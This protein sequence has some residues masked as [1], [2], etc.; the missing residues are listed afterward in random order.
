MGWTV[1]RLVVGL[2][3]LLT[4]F[5]PM[6]IPLPLFS[7]PPA[8]A[9]DILF[10]AIQQATGPDVPIMVA[11]EYGPAE[12]DEMDRVAEPILRH[13]LE[14]GSR[15]VVVSTRPEGPA[16]AQALLTALTSEEERSRRVANLGYQP[17]QATGIQDLLTGPDQRTE[18]NT[19]LPAAQTDAMRGVHTAADVAMIVVLAAQ[20]DDLR[21][22]VEQTSL[23]HPD[24]PLVAGVSARVEPLATPY[25]DPGTGQLQG[26][27]SGLIGATAYEEQ[28]GTGGRA[29]FY[30]NSLGVAQ[31]GMVALMLLGGLIF[32]AGGRRR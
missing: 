21:A 10:Q 29:G 11:F 6:V 12:A 14:Q 25:L 26:L 31:L 9:A 18:I 13:L 30:L 3:L 8:P 4:I 28:L 15:L 24:L 23:T 27:V 22:W 16:V 17:G 1:Q 5:A 19:G 2:L 32:L 7:T 20:P